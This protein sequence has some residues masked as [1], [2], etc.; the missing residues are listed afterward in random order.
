[1]YLGHGCQIGEFCP[2]NDFFS[3]W[4]ETGNIN[5]Q[6]NAWGIFEKIFSSGVQIEIL[7]FQFFWI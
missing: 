1:M 6:G 5:E 2:Q 3:P 4:R 7:F